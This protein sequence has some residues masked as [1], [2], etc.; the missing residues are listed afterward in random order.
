MVCKGKRPW[1][2]VSVMLSGLLTQNNSGAACL[3]EEDKSLP[4]PWTQTVPLASSDLCLHPELPSKRTVVSRHTDCPP[5]LK[6]AAP[7]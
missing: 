2:P 7:F 5:Y 1:L 6:T 3:G 4:V